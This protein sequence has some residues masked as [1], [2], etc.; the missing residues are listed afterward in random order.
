ME[1]IG[2]VLFILLI[3]A[4]VVLG[5]LVNKLV[6][7]PSRQT[8]GYRLSQKYPAKEIVREQRLTRFLGLESAGTSPE[9]VLGTLVIAAGRLGFVST[10]GEHDF[11]VLLEDIHKV[12]L[13]GSHLGFATGMPLLHVTYEGVT[14]VDSVAF[15]LPFTDEWQLALTNLTKPA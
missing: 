4:V 10:D 2:I 14:G 9:S 1:I 8:T 5:Y 6:L 3:V 12:D 11:E 15:H 13:V 7:V